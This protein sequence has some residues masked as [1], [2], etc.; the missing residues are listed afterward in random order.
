MKALSV[1]VARPANFLRNRGLT[2]ESTAHICAL[3]TGDGLADAPI[4]R[5]TAL[6]L[7]HVAGENFG[8]LNARRAPYMGSRAPL[9]G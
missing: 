1:G 6:L 2:P 4:H 3:G 8:S 9:A 5:L 7:E